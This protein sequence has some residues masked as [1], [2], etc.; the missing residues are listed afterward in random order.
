MIIAGLDPTDLVSLALA[1]FA[2]GLIAGVIA[3]LLG[4]GGGIVVVPVLEIML[5]YAGVPLEWRMHVAVATSLATIIPTAISSSRAHHARG[6]VDW[7]VVRSW[8]VPMLAGSLAGSVLAAHA[9]SS[10]LSAIFGFVALAVAIK[11]FLPLDHLRLGDKVP[12]GVAGGVVSAT[13]GG[14]SAMMG[15]GGGT[16]SVP[17][18][19]L[20]GAAVHRAVGTAAF[21][22][23]LISVPGTLGYLFAT[24]PAVLPWG[25]IGLVSLVG[26]AVIAPAS[27][28]T[29]PLGARIAHRLSKRHLSAA[30]GAFLLIVAV[31]MLYRTYIL[32]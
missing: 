14:V 26:F 15:I 32:E 27:F 22:G 29:A 12:R 19:T 30:F 23:L 21:L 25:T 13:I 18:M 24:P 1:M 4:V 20:T 3:G 31:R 6:A 2:T 11:M 17:T 16:L 7:Q 5:R 10:V 8:A 28:I 9:K